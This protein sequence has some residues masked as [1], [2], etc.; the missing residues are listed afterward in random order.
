MIPPAALA[1]RLRHRAGRAHPALRPD[2]AA[3]KLPAP[4]PCSGRC[5]G[6]A[7]V[8]DRFYGTRPLRSPALPSPLGRLCRQ[9][10]SPCAASS[11]AQLS[12]SSATTSRTGSCTTEP[13]DEP[14]QPFG[15][16]GGGRGTRR[17]VLTNVLTP[18]PAVPRRTR[19]ACTRYR[20]RS[21]GCSTTS[22]RCSTSTASTRPTPTRSP[23]RST[24]QRWSTSRCGSPRGRLAAEL[25]WTRR[26]QLARKRLP[27]IAVASFHLRA[28]GGS[29]SGRERIPGGHPLVV[30]RGRGYRWARA[31]P[32][33]ARVEH[34]SDLRRRRR[35][36]P[37]RRHWKSLRHV[38]GGPRLLAKLT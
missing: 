27:K 23:C 8:G 20:W 29:G 25:A 36:C 31:N 38:R 18:R 6:V 21:S 9:P 10:S 12:V 14:T 11:V 24:P 2:S 35:F 15:T 30:R 32:A 5:R 1:R 7:C 19:C 22:R 37:A 16:S 4:A 17:E 33:T 3:R 26:G 28:P 13:E 34:R